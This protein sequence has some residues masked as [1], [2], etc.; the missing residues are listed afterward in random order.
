M[1]A[2]GLPLGHEFPKRIVVVDASM[3]ED[4]GSGAELVEKNQIMADADQGSAE[5]PEDL[6]ERFDLQPRGKA[7]G[8]VKSAILGL[9][10]GRLY[11]IKGIDENLFA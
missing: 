1:F 9:N 8:P 6:Q 5:I 11:D 10:A 7:D 3:V 4:H 2:Q